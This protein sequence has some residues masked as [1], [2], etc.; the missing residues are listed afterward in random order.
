MEFGKA[1]LLLY[2]HS[3]YLAGATFT[4]R[5]PSRPACPLPGSLLRWPGFFCADFRK[6]PACKP[7]YCGFH[8]RNKQLLDN[9]NRFV[10][11]KEKCCVRCL[12]SLDGVRRERVNASVAL[13]GLQIEGICK[14][15][16]GDSLRVEQRTLTPLVLVR[17]QVPQPN[18]LRYNRYHKQ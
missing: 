10:F 8:A 7:V 11:F 13:A 4:C 6:V 3:P 2:S 5:V 17:I 9:R 14:S 15:L 1:G 18:F 12:S 16:L